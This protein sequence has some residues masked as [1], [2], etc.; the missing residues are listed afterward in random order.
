MRPDEVTVPKNFPDRFKNKPLL[1]AIKSLKFSFD[2][3]RHYIISGKT[4]FVKWFAGWYSKEIFYFC[5]WFFCQAG[6]L[7]DTGK[8]KI[9]PSLIIKKKWLKRLSELIFKL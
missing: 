8:H 7:A 1:E 2:N 6:R 9:L 5:Q 3:N 4:E